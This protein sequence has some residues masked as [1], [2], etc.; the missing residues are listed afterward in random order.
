MSWSSPPVSGC[1]PLP[2]AAKTCWTSSWLQAAAN[3]HVPSMR[4]LSCT[5]QTLRENYIQVSACFLPDGEELD[6]GSALMMQSLM[7]IVAERRTPLDSLNCPSLPLMLFS[8][9]TIGLQLVCSVSDA[10]WASENMEFH[11]SA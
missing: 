9:A 2:P 7:Q 1:L 11:F 10:P 5:E 3:L 4:P 6:P 8:Q